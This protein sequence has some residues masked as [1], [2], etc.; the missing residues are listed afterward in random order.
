MCAEDLKVEDG[1]PFGSAL[2]LEARKVKLKKKERERVE[3]EIKRE[4]RRISLV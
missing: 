1:S 4:K 2:G 3:K